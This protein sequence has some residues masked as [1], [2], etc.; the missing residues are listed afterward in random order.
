D[1]S[2][3]RVY[4]PRISAY[5]VIKNVVVLIVTVGAMH[6]AVDPVA[7]A[8]V[9][10]QPQIQRPILVALTSRVGVV[11]VRAVGCTC[12]GIGQRAV[13]EEPEGDRILPRFGNDI[14]G[15]GH[16]T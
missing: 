14:A 8:E 16:R 12:R 6:R 4:F 3:T 5:V 1:H 11:V 15:K 7:A 10:I 2:A 9:V 13:P